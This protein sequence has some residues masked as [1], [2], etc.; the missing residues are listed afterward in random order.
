MNKNL[1]FAIFVALLAI[2]PF[3]NNV[4]LAHETYGA[5]ERHTRATACKAARS[6]AHHH[7]NDHNYSACDCEKLDNGNWSCGV[8]YGQ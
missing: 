5:D 2:P 3:N 7:G 8:T 4:A 6:D 1:I